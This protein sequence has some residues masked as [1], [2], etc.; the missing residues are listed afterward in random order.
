MHPKGLEK[1]ALEFVPSPSTLVPLP[2]VMVTTWVAQEETLQQDKKEM[3][4]LYP[5]LVFSQKMIKNYLIILSL[6]NLQSLEPT[7]PKIRY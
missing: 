4:N 3:E 6:Q 2:A 1:T 5:T 7:F